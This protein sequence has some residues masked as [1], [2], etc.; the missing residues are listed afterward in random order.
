MVYYRG[1]WKYILQGFV[2]PI[3]NVFYNHGHKKKDRLH[4]I[5]HSVTDGAI[6][7]YYNRN[8]LI[9][10]HDGKLLVE[11]LVALGQKSDTYLSSAGR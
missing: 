7:R 10:L 4:N 11:N 8:D 6:D 1:W 2:Q 9:E 3:K 5:A